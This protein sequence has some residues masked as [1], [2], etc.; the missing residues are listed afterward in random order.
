MSELVTVLAQAGLTGRGGAGFPTS[1][2]IALALANRADL[3]VNACDGEV[4]AAKDAHVIAHDVDSVRYAASLVTTGRIW[5][6]AHRGSVTAQ[7]L[8]EA[9]LPVLVVPPRYVSSEESA[10][11]SLAHRGYARPV[12]KTRPVAAGTR[13]SDGRKLRPTLVLN[14]ETML[15]IAQI[16]AHGPQWFRS[17]GTPDEPGP[18]LLAVSGAVAR[19]GVYDA[20]A[21][22]PLG[23]IMTD[24]GADLTRLGGASIGGVSGGCLS[25]HHALDATWSDAGLAPYGLTTGSGVLRV[26]SSSQCP[27]EWVGELAR[28]AAGESA[29][30]CG[31]CMFGLPSVAQDLDQVLAG[32]GSVL[33]RLRH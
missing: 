4:D 25:A 19:P 7:L 26:L 8:R 31:P 3:I 33:P 11:V 29:G 12:T 32:D 21:G 2:K 18:R 6:A 23:Q 9:H 28:Y 15:R 5:Y 1:R 22:M 14:A 24:A 27:W 30:Q 10:L 17:F 20:A 13:T 16:Q